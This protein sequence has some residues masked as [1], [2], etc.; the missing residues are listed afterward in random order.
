MKILLKKSNSLAI[1]SK[2]AAQ[3]L[4]L[5][6][7]GLTLLLVGCTTVPPG[8]PRITRLA[9]EPSATLAPQITQ[10]EAERIAQINAQVLKDQER[11]AENARIA[12]QQQLDRQAYGY[13]YYGYGGGYYGW[14]PVIQ[15]YAYYGGGHRGR[16]WRGGFSVGVPFGYYGWPY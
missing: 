7:I 1:F 2:T 8:P 10:Q 3:P 11:D 6:S 12:R 4:S 5:A 16:G 13:P 14:A 9:P 15:P